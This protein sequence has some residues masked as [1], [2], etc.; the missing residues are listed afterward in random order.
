MTIEILQ[1]AWLFS[2]KGLNDVLESGTIFDIMEAR[3]FLEY[4][5]AEL[6][7]A[8]SDTTQIKKWKMPLKNFKKMG[9]ISRV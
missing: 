6:A 8:R 7:A 9:R 3:D 5:C 4:K 1:N 2:N